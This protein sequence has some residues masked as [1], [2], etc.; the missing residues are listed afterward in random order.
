[1]TTF[2]GIKD[3]SRGKGIM[4]SLSIVEFKQIS[5]NKGCNAISN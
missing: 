5:K 2:F 3:S 4:L 1:M